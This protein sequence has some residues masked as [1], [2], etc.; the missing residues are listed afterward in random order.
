[1]LNHGVNYNL[2]STKVCS[3]AIF[4]IYFSYHKDIWISVSSYYV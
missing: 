4:E 1:M 3:P 2:G